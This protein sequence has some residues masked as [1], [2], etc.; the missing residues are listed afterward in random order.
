MKC[1]NK[2]ALASH[3]KFSHPTHF[4]TGDIFKFTF[5][6]QKFSK[7]KSPILP[8]SASHMVC[9]ASCLVNVPYLYPVRALKPVQPQKLDGRRFNKGTKGKMSR[10][11]YTPVFKAECIEEYLERKGINPNYSQDEYALSLPGKVSQGLF[12]KWMKKKEIIIK[13]ASDFRNVGGSNA[14]L[15]F[16]S[17]A[18]LKHN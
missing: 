13:Q 17:L 18:M 6:E 15:Q 11:A 4:Q 5:K 16:Q 1:I 12:S 9:N 8:T 10:G 2:G 3:K 7:T 14:D